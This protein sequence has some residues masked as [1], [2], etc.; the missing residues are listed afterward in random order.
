MQIKINKAQLLKPLAKVQSI[1]NTNTNLAIT[2]SVLIR[3]EQD[4]ITIESTDLGT[5]YTG[6][7]DA[8][9]DGQC[10][11]AVNAKKRPYLFIKISLNKSI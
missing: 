9:V 1:A 5:G 3:A 8:V 10:A 6:K 2:H 11:F 4:S 7:H